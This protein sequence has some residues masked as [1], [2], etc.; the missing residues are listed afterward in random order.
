M[1]SFFSLTR[2]FDTGS[3]WLLG[4]TLASGALG[5]CIGILGLIYE[6]PSSI[7]VS[8]GNVVENLN[9][10]SDVDLVIRL[11]PYNQASADRLAIGH[12][13]TLGPESVDYTFVADYSE[14][15]G[16]HAAEAAEMLGGSMNGATHVS[17]II[18]PEQLNTSQFPEFVPA[19]ARGLLQVIRAI[20]DLHRRD[21][22]YTKPFNVTDKLRELNLS[23]LRHA[24]DEVQDL[25]K[26]DKST[27]RWNNYGPFYQDYC[28]AAKMFLSGDFSA[29]RK[30]SNIGNDWHALGFAQ[31]LTNGEDP[32]SAPCDVSDWGVK[33]ATL[34][35]VV[36]VRVF[37]I[38]NIKLHDLQDQVLIDFYF[39]KIQFIPDFHNLER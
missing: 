7:R 10:N 39:P 34:K 18:F 33:T 26:S 12:L 20:D 29:R 27:Y 6:P 38:R 16:Y 30:I 11:V 32:D 37:L 36:G 19:N 14:V 17:A 13:P 23:N 4:T 5:V 15:R 24:E 22:D 1:R 31:D 21:A 8:Q 9:R 25:G 2:P 28:H 3:K 35:S